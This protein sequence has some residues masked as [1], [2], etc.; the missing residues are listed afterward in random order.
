LRLHVANA[1]ESGKTTREVSAIYQVSPAFVSNIHQYWRQIGHVHSKQIGDYR[2][3]LLEHFKVR[4]KEQ[5]SSHPS[6][7]LKELQ[8]WLASEQGYF[9]H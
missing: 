1:V 9:S 6:M 5:L 8:A 3:A 2:R 4:L 7:T